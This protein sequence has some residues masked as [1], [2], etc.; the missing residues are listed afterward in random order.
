MYSNR[1]PAGHQLLQSSRMFSASPRLMLANTLRALCLRHSAT[2]H[3]DLNGNSSRLLRSL[4]RPAAAGYGTHATAAAAAVQEVQDNS[5][6]SIKANRSRQTQAATN[7]SSS[8]RQTLDYTALVAC[9]RELSGSWVPS[10]VEEVTAR[11]R[12]ITVQCFAQHSSHSISCSV[13][14]AILMEPATT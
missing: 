7:S 4:E 14:P 1:M 13:A 5:N 2:R 10:K 3:A 9:C 8:S 11:R 6:R 12:H